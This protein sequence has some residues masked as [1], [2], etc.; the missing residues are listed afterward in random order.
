MTVLPT[1]LG[2][3]VSSSGFKALGKQSSQSALKTT[4]QWY[5]KSPKKEAF[6]D[7]AFKVAPTLNE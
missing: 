2:R 5:L 7:P 1:G 6:Y 4:Q 3:Q